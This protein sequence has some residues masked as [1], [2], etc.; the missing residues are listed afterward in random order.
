MRSW[1]RPRLVGFVGASLL[2]L[3]GSYGLSALRPPAAGP[4]TDPG[5][6]PDGAPPAAFALP[7]EAPSLDRGS[8]ASLA[9]IDRSIAAWTKNLEA[10]DRDF[11]SAT[12]LA[13]LLHGRGRLSGDLGDH[14]RA[15]AA[16]RTA[17][18][19]EPT[20][21]PARALEAAILFTLHD[22]GGALAAADRLI[23][24]D[25][26]QIGALATR[27]DA[28]LEL[29]R[30]DEARAD[31]E[32][33]RAVG[34][35]AVTIRAARLASVT[36][37]PIRALE[38][39][40]S[41]QGA[42]LDDETADGAFYAYAVGEYAR[43]AGDAATARA[44]Y[45]AALAIRDDDIGAL[46]GLAR[47][48]AFEERPAAA[49]AGLE[50]ATAIVPQPDALALLGDLRVAVGDPAAAD[51]F[52]TVRFIGQLGEAQQVAYDRALLRFELDHDWATDGILARAEASR[53]ARPDWTG[54]DTVAWALYRL[55]RF[56]EAAAAIEAARALG[57]DDA[58]LRFHA[59]AIALARGDAAAGREWLEAAL[60]LGPAL[61]P[62]ER[63][64][65]TRL[66]D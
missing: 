47:I 52:A 29:G 4:A 42:A 46:V 20:H 7:G 21:A 9:Q 8:S 6:R 50:R 31:L 59:G 1:R 10:N 32:R 64:E 13:L 48:D 12:N 3:A 5:T 36:G 40:R 15:L 33:L 28:A 66:L 17:L 35:P 55:G 26:V 63:A 11:L 16:A 18:D 2:I 30:I 49:I 45:E 44:G 58:R 65:V 39:A 61:D 24:D 54:H 62:I 27:F 19:I 22:F 43:L 60:A 56:D 34:G 51:A 25:P 23:A 41:A 38:L 14:E 37:D 57:A 53:I